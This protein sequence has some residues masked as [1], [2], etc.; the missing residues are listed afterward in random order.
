MALGWS[1]DGRRVE[2]AAAFPAGKLVVKEQ[3]QKTH[4]QKLASQGEW[5]LPVGTETFAVKRVKAFMGPK[6]EL[7]RGDAKVP[8]TAKHVSPLPAAP[9]SV[10]ASHQA[11]AR[12]A[13]ARCGGFSCL[14]CAGA[15]LT[16][17]TSCCALL[18]KDAEKN[19]A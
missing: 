6:T 9:G 12:Y 4:E 16:H 7:F 10:C 18:L 8:P 1:I 5:S 2:F 19:A 14:Q 15:D 11:A 17:C 13:C 3:G